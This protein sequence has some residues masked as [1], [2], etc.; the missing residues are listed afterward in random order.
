M[1]R[2]KKSETSRTKPRKRPATSP[3][4][5]EKQLISLAYDVAEQQLLDGTISASALTQLLKAGSLKT[6]YEIEKLRRDNELAEA[7]TENLRAAKRIDELYEA[8]MNAMRSYSGQIENR[9]D[10]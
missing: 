10:D 3:E 4:A 2:P 6:E 9:H 5:R 7:K 1:A 8:A